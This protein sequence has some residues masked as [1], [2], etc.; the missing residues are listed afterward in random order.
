MTQFADRALPE[1]AGRPKHRSAVVR[2][3][4][5]EASCSDAAARP[6]GVI[7]AAAVRPCAS[8][9]ARPGPIN[10]DIRECP[11]QP[12]LE[13]LPNSISFGLRIWASSPVEQPKAR[14][15]R[16]IPEPIEKPGEAAAVVHAP[17]IINA[18][19]LGSRVL[20]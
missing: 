16:Q 19:A 20:I 4:Q 11:A 14:A 6:A 3:V 12:I 15:D 2:S 13:P 17:E 5:I 7:P 1:A 9:R 8:T 18:D 10:I